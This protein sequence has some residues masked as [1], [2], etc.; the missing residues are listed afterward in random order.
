MVSRSFGF[1]ERLGLVFLEIFVIFLN[2]EIEILRLVFKKYLKCDGN[3]VRLMIF[4]GLFSIY[5]WFFLFG[6]CCGGYGDCLVILLVVIFFVE[7]L[8]I[9]IKW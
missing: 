5:F 4:E 9:G 3:F 1:C 6:N 7:L 8:I 2:C